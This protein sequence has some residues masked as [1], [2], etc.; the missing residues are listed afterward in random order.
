MEHLGMAYIGAPLMK[1]FFLANQNCQ[2]QK[3]YITTSTSL[4]FLHKRSFTELFWKFK[5]AE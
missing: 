3:S 5:M 4:S 1:L 2:K